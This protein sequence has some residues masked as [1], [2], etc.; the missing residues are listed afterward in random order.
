VSCSLCQTRKEKRFCLAVHSRI[1]PQCC[2]EQRE[3]S[4][5]CPS[6]C[7]YL[8]QAREHERPRPMNELNREDLFPSVEIEESFLYQH[9]NLLM[10]VTFA[11]AKSARANRDLHDTDLIAAL[12]ALGKTYQILAQSGLHYETATPNP[13][14]QAVV[15]E[16]KKMLGEFR[17]VEQ[18]HR[19]HSSLKDSDVLKGLVFLTRMALG[20][21]SGRPKSKAFV[22]FL[23]QQFPEKAPVAAEETGSRIIIP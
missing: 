10:G 11:L 12:T 2:G 21:T 8:Q 23:F 6:E 4:L 7:V 5:D 17:Q 13:D 9:E 1:C 3:V 19:G 18:E 14:Q 22:D 20:R 16:I 15:E